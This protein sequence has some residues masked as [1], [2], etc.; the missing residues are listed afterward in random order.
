MSEREQELLSRIFGLDAALKKT[1][2][3]LRVLYGSDARAK[4]RVMRDEL[5]ASSRRAVLCTGP[6]VSLDSQGAGS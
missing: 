2:E 1:L 5:T 3:E 6:S 4:L